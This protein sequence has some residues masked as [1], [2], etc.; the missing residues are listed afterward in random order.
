MTNA[1]HELK[2]EEFAPFFKVEDGKLIR[3]VRSRK[4]DVRIC[5]WS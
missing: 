1:R 2:Y 3:T 5:G 4:Q